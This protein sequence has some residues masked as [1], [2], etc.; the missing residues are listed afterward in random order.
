MR[1]KNEFLFAEYIGTYFDLIL[2]I[3]QNVRRP[4]D[5]GH[6]SESYETV[7]LICL[8]FALNHY[9]TSYTSILILYHLE[10]VSSDGCS[11]LFTIYIVYFSDYLSF[12]SLE[13]WS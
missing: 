10:N 7:L 8:F 3:N 9:N 11:L 6:L 1:T 13:I 4:G 2:N 5:Q 12:L